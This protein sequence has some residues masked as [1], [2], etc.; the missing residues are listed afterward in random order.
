MKYRV[1]FFTC[2]GILFIENQGRRY[3]WARNAD[4]RQSFLSNR[5]SFWT[6]CSS[7]RHFEA[8]FGQTSPARLFL[9]SPTLRLYD[10]LCL[11]VIVPGV[12]SIPIDVVVMNGDLRDVIRDGWGSRP[13][14]AVQAGRRV[15][16]FRRRPGSYQP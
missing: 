15:M 16:D 11:N 5:L 1:A 10:A 6:T 9:D 2:Q 3:L 14:C 4:R 13:A 8:F 12:L 7:E